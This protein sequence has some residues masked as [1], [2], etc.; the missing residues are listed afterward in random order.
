MIFT[1]SGTTGQQVSKHSVAS[2]ELYRWSFMAS[3]LHAYSITDR[4]FQSDWCVLALLPSYL[5]RDGSSL[6]YMAESMIDVTRSNGS[7]FY[8]DDHAALMRA[9]NKARLRR[10][11]VLLLG[12]SFALLDLADS[13]SL[14]LDG[15]IV[16]ETGGMKGKRRE[17]VRQELHAELCS[18][19][20]IETIHSEYGM[21]ELLS[22]AYSKG[23][24][25]FMTPPW[26]KVMI[27]QADDPLTFEN[28]G[29]TGGV[30]VIDLANLHSCAFIGTS[31]LGR[32]HADQ[33]FEI[34]GRFDTSD[35]RGCNLL[36]TS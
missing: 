5:E 19:F 24:G 18:K 29:R 31:D 36:V 12:V 34:L 27:R 26:M 16:M 3:F 25:R 6:I 14:Q 11:R 13:Y 1:S 32:L 35:I 9:L 15:V 30:N 7:G 17:M 8:L 33:S 10:K 4:D 20:S 28:D 2:L 21:T 22:Q 23:D